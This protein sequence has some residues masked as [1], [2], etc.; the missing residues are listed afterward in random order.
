MYLR[1]TT[2]MRETSPYGWRLRGGKPNYHSGIDLGNRKEKGDPILAVGNGIVKVSK[3][4]KG[5]YGNYIVVE[6]DGWCALYAHLSKSLVKVGQKLLKY[7]TIAE[8]GNTGHSFGEHLHFEVRD[9]EYG[10]FWDRYDNR[11]WVH[12]VDPNYFNPNEK[13]L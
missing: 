10:R 7:E 13:G 8:M 11:M 6:H 3:F 5:G 4:D 12:C 9:V 1:P 2:N